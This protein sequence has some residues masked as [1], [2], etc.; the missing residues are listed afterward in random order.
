MRI[1]MLDNEY[2]P[3]GG[4]MG[5]ANQALLRIFA[6]VPDMEIDLITAALGSHSEEE[7][8]SPKISI[9]KVPVNNKNIHHSSNRELSAYAYQALGLAYRLHRNRHYDFCFAWSALPAGAVARALKAWAGLPYMVWVSG[10][11]IPGYERRYNWLYPFLTPLLKATWRNATP[12]IAKC[13]EEIDTIHRVDPTVHVTLI[14]NGVDCSSFRPR[15]PIPDNG[16]L[17]VIC[18][19]RLIE[20]KGQHHLI[21]SVKDLADAGIPVQLDLVGTGDS[22]DSYRGLARRL[23]VE[24][25]VQFSGYVPRE[26]IPQCYAAAHVFALPSFSEGMALAALEAM[27]VGLPLVLTRTG[28]T[29]DLVEEG[30][31]GLT[32]EWGD[33]ASLTAHLRRLAVDRPLA[34]RMGAASRARSARFSWEGI[35]STYCRLFQEFGHTRSYSVVRG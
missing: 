10:P 25:N 11:D 24:S 34:R 23:G 4:G 22:L 27:S 26:Q 18:V 5:T 16:P 15:S 21:R 6:Y 32:F 14:P 17:N 19:A 35:G 2:P 9:Y 1:L 13:A 12:L 20:R 29:Q 7:Q 31:N 33:W 8:V 3:L 28:G 30:V